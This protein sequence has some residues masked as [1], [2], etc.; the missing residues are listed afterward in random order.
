MPIQRK[1]AFQIHRQPEEYIVS[2]SE[3]VWPT[4]GLVKSELW[5]IEILL[6]GAYFRHT[7]WIHVG[8]TARTQICV[9]SH[10]SVTIGPWERCFL[11]PVVEGCHQ[12]LD[13]FHKLIQ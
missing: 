4:D 8:V 3:N 12:E 11:V 7:V 1:N 9:L 2:E 10:M 6:L 5:E 13:M